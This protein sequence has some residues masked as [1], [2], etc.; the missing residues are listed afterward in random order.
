MGVKGTAN[1]PLTWRSATNPLWTLKPN[2]T[3]NTHA[4]CIHYLSTKSRQGQF[5][6]IPPGCLC[7]GANGKEIDYGICVLR[8]G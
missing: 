7:D 8:L 2:S 6:A 4:A 5:H 1:I 3:K